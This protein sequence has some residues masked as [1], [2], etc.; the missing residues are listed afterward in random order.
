MRAK[1][2]LPERPSALFLVAVVD[3]LAVLLIFSTLIP[4]IAQQ[5]G[6]VIDSA[7]SS[8]RAP[9]VRLSDKISLILKSGPQ[10]AIYLDDSRIE[11]DDLEAELERRRD[12]DGIEWVYI[13]PDT[14]AP[15]GLFYAVV[16]K[17][18][19]AGLNALGGGT[20]KLHDEEEGAP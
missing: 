9:N 17:V 8:S 18:I 20:L 11:L 13:L 12:E 6:V 3:L 2:T 7:E 15:T 16:D 14:Q 5:G 1:L 19:A 4:A 10:P